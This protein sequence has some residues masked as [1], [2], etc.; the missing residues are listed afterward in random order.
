VAGVLIT[1]VGP[2]VV[3]MWCTCISV[4][5]V[6]NGVLDYDTV[7]SGTWE[8]AICTR[9]DIAASTLA[10]LTFRVFFS[11]KL[12]EKFCNNTGSLFY[13]LNTVCHFLPVSTLVFSGHSAAAVYTI[14]EPTGSIQENMSHKI[15]SLYLKGGD[16]RC[17]R[18]RLK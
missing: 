18:L 11:S 16:E 12:A 9:F 1:I 15:M 13:M 17:L 7:Q 8:R 3:W 14:S 10:N 5:D 4:G 6:C 2:V